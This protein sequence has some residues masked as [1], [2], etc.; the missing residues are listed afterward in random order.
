MNQ[1]SRSVVLVNTNVAFRL[2]IALCAPVLRR[3]RAFC[4]LTR[5]IIN[6][7]S[8]STCLYLYRM[9]PRV[10]YV[11]ISNRSTNEV[12]CHISPLSSCSHPQPAIILVGGNSSVGN[13]ATDGHDQEGS[14]VLVVVAIVFGP[15]AWSPVLWHRPLNTLAVISAAST[16]LCPPQS[17]KITVAECF[18]Q[19]SLPDSG[20]RSR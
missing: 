6:S 15:A 16:W 13:L 20:A 12:S 9:S 2:I 14:P 10:D 5:N 7:A 1:L 3:V 4:A 17:Q 8:D 18:P 19:Y 11:T